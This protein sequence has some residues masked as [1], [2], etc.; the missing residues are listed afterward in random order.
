MC[1]CQKLLQLFDLSAMRVRS[2]DAKFRPR[3]FQK[4]LVAIFF[5]L[6]RLGFLQKTLLFSL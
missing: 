4:L 3:F 2:N 5:L 1:L 6:C